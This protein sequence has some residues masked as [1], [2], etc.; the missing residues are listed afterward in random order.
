MDIDHKT[1]IERKKHDLAKYLC[2]CSV[3]DR[4]NYIARMKTAWAR[5]E[6]RAAYHK[7]KA[8][9]ILTW[10][11]EIRRAYLSK[12]ARLDINQHAAI[13]NALTI[14]ELEAARKADHADNY[15]TA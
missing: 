5:N 11:L 3:R 4:E 14:F 15:I 6:L 7:E 13:N 2:N 8:R 1:T 12:L 9:Q 10:P